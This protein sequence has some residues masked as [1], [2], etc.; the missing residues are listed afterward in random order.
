MTRS[1]VLG[2]KGFIGSHLVDAL[3]GRG[4]QVICFDRPHVSPLAPTSAAPRD[5]LE[6][7]EGDLLCEA[8]IAEAVQGCDACFHLVSTTLPKSSNSD[9]VFDVE[10]NLIGT[11]RL[12]QHAVA[13][14]VRKIVFISS[15]GTVYG[16]VEELPIPETHATNPICSYGIT[17]LAIEKYLNLFHRLHGLDYCILRVA[18]PFGERQRVDAAQGAIAVFLGKALRHEPIEIWG[19]GSVVRDYIHVDDVVSALLA[20]QTYRGDDKVFNIG[21]GCGLS[22]SEVLAAIEDAI[23]SPIQRRYVEQRCF[24]VPANVLCIEKAIR[25]LGWSPKVPF[26]EG[27][28]RYVRWLRDQMP[29][30]SARRAA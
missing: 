11:L 21:S 2:G 9:P 8:D 5:R 30:V 28:R 15:G 16:P 18:N 17:K 14:G 3:L 23:G 12:L 19:D 27:L 29:A 20:A 13:A 4:D 26:H 10:S 1:L 25:R 24:D 7:I 6:V 22:V